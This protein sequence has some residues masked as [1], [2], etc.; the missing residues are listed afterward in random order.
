MT[1]VDRETHG[2]HGV[3]KVEFGGS[4]LQHQ[5][6]E[7]FVSSGSWGCCSSQ[8]VPARIWSIP[9]FHRFWG[10]SAAGVFVFPIT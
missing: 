6:V 5:I 2:S 1:G 9:P 10:W 4:R 7:L 8:D 3:R